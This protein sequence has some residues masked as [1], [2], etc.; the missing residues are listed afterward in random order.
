[1][2]V[3]RDTNYPAFKWNVRERTCTSQHY[4]DF[5]EFGLEAYLL[6]THDLYEYLSTTWNFMRKESLK[7]ADFNILTRI[8]STKHL[9]IRLQN[10]G[11]THTLSLTQGYCWWGRRSW[12][13]HRQV[14][15]WR[16]RQRRRPHSTGVG[17]GSVPRSVLRTLSWR[18]LVPEGIRRFKLESCRN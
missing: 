4:L 11:H 2:N 17:N 5:W 8:K 9:N 12:D 1:M 15:C 7:S 3:T 13:W 6:N 10:L 14:R 18:T 16:R